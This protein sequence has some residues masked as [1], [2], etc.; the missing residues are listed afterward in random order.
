MK[1]VLQGADQLTEE[2]ILS[3]MAAMKI[4]GKARGCPT[5]SCSPTLRS[6]TTSC[7]WKWRMENEAAGARLE[8]YTD[9]CKAREKLDGNADIDCDG[10]Q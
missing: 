3:A 2:R 5:G 10:D 6:G 8:F 9:Q 1:R 4:D 7:R